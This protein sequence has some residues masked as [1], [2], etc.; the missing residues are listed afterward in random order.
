MRQVVRHPDRLR[1][2][3][4]AGPVRGA[5]VKGGTEDD[6]IGIGIRLRLVEIAP[7]DAE[8]GDVRTELR[9]IASHAVTLE[10]HP[11][12]AGAASTS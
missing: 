8:E 1:P 6:D 7:V 9:A 5:P 2:K 10:R 3:A 4:R 11:T 12:G